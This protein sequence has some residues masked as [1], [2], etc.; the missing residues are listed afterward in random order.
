MNSGRIA[1]RFNWF[2]ILAVT[3]TVVLIVTSV[4]AYLIHSY[5]RDLIEKDRLHLKG[6]A[7]SVKGFI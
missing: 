6:L 1:S 7:S 2:I 4:S 5:N 3:V